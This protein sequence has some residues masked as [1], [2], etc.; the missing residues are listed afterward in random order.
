MSM[1]LSREQLERLFAEG[2][3]DIDQAYERAR[4][5]GWFESLD[6]VAARKAELRKA[7]NA[8]KDK[9]GLQAIISIEE[10]D[11]DGTRRRIY[12]TRAMFD[13][14][15]YER[16]ISYVVKRMNYYHQQGVALVLEGNGKFPNAQLDL[17]LG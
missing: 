9:N 8:H 3:G 11:G 4:E 13:L 1:R 10:V 5:L 12:K 17:P 14:A 6:E 15:D 2:W 16:S 7:I